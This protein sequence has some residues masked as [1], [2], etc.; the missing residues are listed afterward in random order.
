MPKLELGDHDAR[1]AL[2][3]DG[4]ALFID[5]PRMRRGD[6]TLRDGDSGHTNPPQG[7][8]DD[9]PTELPPGESRATRGEHAIGVAP[10]TCGLDG[11][12][13][14]ALA[15]DDVGPNPSRLDGDENESKR[16]CRVDAASLVK[17]T[18]SMEVPA[19]IFK[20]DSGR[21]GGSADVTL[22][23]V[24]TSADAVR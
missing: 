5:A 20:H 3:T 2:L 22:F 17:S 11:D 12:S 15:S 23:F 16:C 19:S 13:G 9:F 10:A 7:A 18:R 21:L 4:C 1:C 14:C 6:E 24:V 8:R